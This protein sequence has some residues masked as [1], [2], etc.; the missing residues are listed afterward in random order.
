MLATTKANEMIFR[1]TCSTKEKTPKQESFSEHMPLNE[2]GAVITGFE[3]GHRL[4][5]AFLS[6]GNL[7]SGIARKIRWKKF[8]IQ[9]GKLSF[10]N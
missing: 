8:Q 1:C 6:L 5:K 3:F 9:Y 7:T 10:Q 2:E 4:Q